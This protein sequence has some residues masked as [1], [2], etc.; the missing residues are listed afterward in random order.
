[1]KIGI[2]GLGEIGSAVFK[3]IAKNCSRENLFGIDIDDGKFQELKLLGYNVGTS[4]PGLMDVYIITVWTT[5]QVMTV[6]RGLDMSN[7]P[8]VVIE[9]TVDMETCN[10]LRVELKDKEFDLVAFPHRY[11]GGDFEHQIFN[12]KRVMGGITEVGLMRGRNF[13]LNFMD[14]KL[15]YLVNDIRSAEA[16]KVIENA[17]RYVEIALAQELRMSLE[18]KGLDWK[19]VIAACNTKWNI[20]ILE[21]RGGIGKHCLPKDIKLFNVLF[22]SNTLF[23]W[24]ENSNND[25]IKYLEGVNGKK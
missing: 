13:F 12:L 20:N 1:M 10:K 4:F 5:E 8:L 3:A 18:S 6:V 2:I 25:Y 9:S 11:N 15:I 23:N 17:Y 14:P 21:P 19:E 22:S 7:N 24:A 16:C